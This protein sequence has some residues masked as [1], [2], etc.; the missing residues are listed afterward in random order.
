LQEQNVSPTPHGRKPLPSTPRARS[1]EAQRVRDRRLKDGSTA[2][3]AVNDHIRGLAN[4]V[5]KGTAARPVRG[6]NTAR[7]AAAAFGQ[8]ISAGWGTRELPGPA[9]IEAWR[10]RGWIDKPVPFSNLAARKAMA[11]L[12]KISPL[13]EDIGGG[14]YRIHAGRPSCLPP[15]ILNALTDVREADEADLARLPDL[16]FWMSDGDASA[17]GADGPERSVL[18]DPSS[19]RARGDSALLELQQEQEGFWQASDGEQLWLE[20]DFM[21]AVAGSMSDPA[22]VVEA[23]PNTPP[24]RPEIELEVWSGTISDWGRAVP[25]WPQLQ[26]AARLLLAHLSPEGFLGTAT[27]L[28]ATL[29]GFDERTRATCRSRA[30]LVRALESLRR[31]GLLLV[32]GGCWRLPVFRENPTLVMFDLDVPPDPRPASPAQIAALERMGVDTEGLG[33]SEAV[34]V[35]KR[36]HTRRKRGQA[37]PRLLA[38]VRR[39]EALAGLPTDLRKLGRLD[40]AQAREAMRVAM[41]RRRADEQVMQAEGWWL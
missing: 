27:E 14:W 34:A 37:H 15:R 30:Q 20:S 25:M 32:T 35:S 2:V 10:Q 29:A 7:L 12:A 31:R 22:E 36:L 8:A 17:V 16:A 40:V 9:I 33:H 6:G 26:R 41:K 11:Q 18:I 5:K 3:R 38:A 24:A 19:E 28:A 23:C 1:F 4:R 13:A 21:D 39:E